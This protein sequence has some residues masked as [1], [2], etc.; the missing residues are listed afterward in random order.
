MN[1]LILTVDIDANDNALGHIVDIHKINYGEIVNSM[2][3]KFDSPEELFQ[4]RIDLLVREINKSNKDLLIGLAIEKAEHLTDLIKAIRS[5]NHEITKIFYSNDGRR[6]QK[7]ENY[8][9]EHEMHGRWL[10]YTSE[11]VE[12]MNN[13]FYTKVEI[14]ID[15]AENFG[16]ECARI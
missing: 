9:K 1:K 16:I 13:A 3:P 11:E 15:T 2:K 5:R 10:G 7:I 8:K 12:E 4:I 6:K 14:L